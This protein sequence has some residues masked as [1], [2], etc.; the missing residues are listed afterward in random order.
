MTTLGYAGVVAPVAQPNDDFDLPPAR[1]PASA[2]AR[3]SAAPGP[4]ALAVGLAAVPAPIFVAVFRYL[5]PYDD[6]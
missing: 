1:L 5:I 3:G 6:G 4:V 2:A